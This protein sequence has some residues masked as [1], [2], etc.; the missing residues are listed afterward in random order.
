MHARDLLE[1]RDVAIKI[2]KNQEQFANQAAQEVN[3]LQRLNKNDPDDSKHIGV[4]LFVA[5]FRGFDIYRVVLGF[6]LHPV[7]SVCHFFFSIPKFR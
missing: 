6:P 5:R 2:I 1:D 7:Y 3:I 4:S